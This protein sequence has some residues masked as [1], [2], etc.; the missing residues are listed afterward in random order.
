MKISSFNNSQLYRKT[1]AIGSTHI[2]SGFERSQY[3]PTEQSGYQQRNPILE[4][5][6]NTYDLYA[7]ENKLAGTTNQNQVRKTFSLNAQQSNRLEASI[8][9]NYIGLKPGQAEYDLNE[10]TKGYKGKLI[11][12]FAVNII[13][14]INNCNRETEERF[15][16]TMPIN[17]PDGVNFHRAYG[18]YDQY[19]NYQKTGQIFTQGHL[20]R[21]VDGLRYFEGYVKF[22]VKGQKPYTERD[23][24]EFDESF[25][26]DISAFRNLFAR[27]AYLNKSNFQTNSFERSGELPF[28]LEFTYQ[29]R[30][31]LSRTF[32]NYT[33]KAQIMN[34]WASQ[35]QGGDDQI[36]SSRGQG[37]FFYFKPISYRQVPKGSR[38]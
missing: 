24:D 36:F 4:G 34:M 9:E 22:I 25:D 21:R 10:I 29:C 11:S 6:V 3:Y 14:S 8:D 12:G 13:P 33:H 23:S 5:N 16:M 37:Y 32:N 19:G 15:D 20:A 2:M 27:S 38:F 17:F 35:R 26:S 30:Y 31:P 18:R 1:V 28:D 7:A